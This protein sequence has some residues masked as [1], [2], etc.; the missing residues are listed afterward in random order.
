[1]TLKWYLSKYDEREDSSPAQEVDFGLSLQKPI[2]QEQTANAN[3]QIVER[4]V[5]RGRIVGIYG[6][7]GQIDIL[8]TRQHIQKDQQMCVKMSE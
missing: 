7:V 4:V 6:S 8:E 2:Q 1:M 5:Q 3:L